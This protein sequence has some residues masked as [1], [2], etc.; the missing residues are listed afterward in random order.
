MSRIYEGGGS[1]RRYEG[2][3]RGA[4]YQ[5]RQVAS[6]EKELRQQQEAVLQDLATRER[7]RQRDDLLYNKAQATSAE[8]ARLQLNAEQSAAAAEFRMIQN[9][10]RFALQRAQLGEEQLLKETS[11][12]GANSLANDI[13]AMSQGVQNALLE[14]SQLI[15]RNEL[16]GKQTLDSGFLSMNQDY[17]ANKLNQDLVFQRGQMQGQQSLENSFLKQQ[18]LASRLITEQN[19]QLQ[20]DSLKQNQQIAKGNLKQTQQYQKSA[21][22]QTQLNDRSRLKGQN[23][24][25]NSQL[26]ANQ[27]LSKDLLKSGQALESMQLGEKLGTQNSNLIAQQNLQKS[28]T[29]ASL[30]MKNDFLIANTELGAEAR[31]LT[32]NQAIERA[33]QQAQFASERSALSKQQAGISALMSFA[34][35]ATGAAEIVQ[36]YNTQQEKEQAAAEKLEREI[37]E[38]YAFLIGTDNSVVQADGSVNPVIATEQAIQAEE[39]AF[40]SGVQAVSAGD[41]QTAENIRQ[42]LADQTMNRNV[43]QMGISEASMAFQGELDARLSDPSYAIQT[44]DGRILT[45]G[46]VR[47]EAEL[48]NLSMVSLNRSPLSS[49]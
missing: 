49:G 17:A 30:A 48:K 41:L 18:Q 23:S 28:Q 39:V 22:K 27:Q 15:A 46:S 35:I 7:E 11:M 37:A 38:N 14:Q 24:L 1:D 6:N 43:R 26:K 12:K 32:A 4:S 3:T 19:Q 5:P 29:N 40:E 45:I 8:V 2:R 36:D 16:K 21:L 47:S 10:E 9:A 44:T 33:E 25:N 34:K 13:L 42:P 31:A 20:S